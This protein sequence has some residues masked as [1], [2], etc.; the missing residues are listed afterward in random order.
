M[1][2]FTT[3]V[4]TQIV[5]LTPF[6]RKKKRLPVYPTSIEENSRSKPGSILYILDIMLYGASCEKRVI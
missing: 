1:L 5:V 3:L 6:F 2:K 4:Y